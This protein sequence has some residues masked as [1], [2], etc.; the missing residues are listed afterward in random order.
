MDKNKIQ[1]DKQSIGE[2]AINHKESD[3]KDINHQEKQRKEK[4]QPRDN[5]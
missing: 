5:A 1:K 3:G 4:H 2:K